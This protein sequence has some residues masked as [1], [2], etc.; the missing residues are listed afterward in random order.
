M[1]I[2]DQWREGI[3]EFFSVVLGV[4]LLSV[5][6]FVLYL[7]LT[8][9]G[10]SGDTG[11]SRVDCVE[12]VNDGPGHPDLDQIY[13]DRYDDVLEDEER[14]RQSERDE[15]EQELEQQLEDAREDGYRDGYDNARPHDD[16][17]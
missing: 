15:L 10:S 8:S 7:I 11:C 5:A 6:A 3:R 14:Q 1:G 17:G 16:D 4:V 12:Q 13:Q 2:G 9:G